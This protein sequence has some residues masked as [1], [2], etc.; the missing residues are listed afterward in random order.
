MKSDKAVLIGVLGLGTA[1]RLISIESRPIQY[2]DAFSVFL[3]SQSFSKIIS[4][5]AA[6]T[7]PPLY[8]F[9]LHFWLKAGD[10]LIWLRLS[11]VLLGMGV[12]IG[13]YYWGSILYDEKAGLGAAF[14]A[15][16]SPLQIYHAQDLRMY[17]LLA[18]AQTG[19]GI[20]FSLILKNSQPEHP[21][22]TRDKKGWFWVGLTLCGAIAMYSHAL[23]GFFLIVPEILAVIK[24]QWGVLVKLLASK[25]I[26]GIIYLPWLLMLPGQIAKVQRAFW[27]PPPG[28]AE[29]IQAL[30]LWHSNLPLPGVWLWAAAI[31]SL[32]A[33]VLVVFET[34]RDRELKSG[35][36]VFAMF[37]I[38][39]PLLLIVFSY[40]MRPVFVTRG[41]ITSQLTY[42]AISGRVVTGKARG[43]GL[44]T[45]AFTAAAVI[46]LP[47]YYV[48][49]EFPRS[50]YPD[51]VNYLQKKMINGG[52]VVH[53]NKLSYFPMRYYGPVLDQ[54]FLPDEPGSFNDTLAPESQEA[55]QIFPINDLQKAAGGRDQIDFVVFN[56][57][58]TEYAEAN[59]PHPILENL[60]S[61]C[62]ARGKQSFNDLEI[63][64]FNCS[65]W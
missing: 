43:R 2:D 34:Y 24:R 64:G 36:H 40:L 53:D 42:L 26:I 57:S 5:T 60:R 65:A 27:T 61:N 35:K 9:W 59:K 20:F 56:R 10:N 4:G 31:F 47:F 45:A 63:Y 41:F 16:I 14:L 30:I 48:F 62:Q 58:L 12:V 17:T 51:A 7:M 32:E 29:V 54:V 37:T 46:S 8:Y 1:L 39:P 33:I 15:A 44:V 23:A 19:Y 55:M 21:S 22:P 18:L 38:L 11:S 3:S 28:I 49:A 25:I 50:P 6:D 52:L 13:M